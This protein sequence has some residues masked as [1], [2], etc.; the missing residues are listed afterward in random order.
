MNP[1]VSVAVLLSGREQFSSYYGGAVARWTYE[2][3]IRLLCQSARAAADLEQG[4][5]PAKGCVQAIHVDRRNEA[6]FVN[7]CD[8][9]PRAVG[10]RRVCG[11]ATEDCNPNAAHKS[12]IHNRDVPDGLTIYIHLRK[13]SFQLSLSVREITV[14]P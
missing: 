3:Y 7:A 6:Y 13:T 12:C 11:C 5:R 4:T 10:V 9:R 8:P 1:R 14:Y 2:G